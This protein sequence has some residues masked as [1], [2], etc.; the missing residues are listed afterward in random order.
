MLGKSVGQN[1]PQD[2]SWK[3]ERKAELQDKV[4]HWVEAAKTSGE[5]ES[6]L[7]PIS[8]SFVGE[9]FNHDDNESK[10]NLRH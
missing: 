6:T 7:S 4:R 3:G 8:L 2:T 10:K 9:K 1:R 5:V